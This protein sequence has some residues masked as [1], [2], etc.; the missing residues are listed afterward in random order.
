MDR[1]SDALETGAYERCSYP[2]PGL[3]NRLI[4]SEDISLSRDFIDPIEKACPALAS[5]SGVDSLPDSPVFLTTPATVEGGAIGIWCSHRVCC[6]V[7]LKS[8]ASTRCGEHC[9]RREE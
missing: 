9:R 2:V 5:K 4:L 3:G 1:R 8:V 7:Q 6:H